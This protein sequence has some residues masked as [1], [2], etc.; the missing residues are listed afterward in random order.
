MKK[1]AIL[2]LTALTVILITACAWATTYYVNPGES[3]QAAINSSV[4]GDVVIVSPGTYYENIN[5]NGKDIV[6]TS[7]DPTD[8]IIRNATIIDAGYSGSVVS[9]NGSESSACV[10]SG[11]TIFNGRGTWNSYGY[12]GGGIYGNNTNATIQDN[13]IKNNISGYGGGLALCDGLIKDNIITG[14]TVNVSYGNGAG[15]HQCDGTIQGN[16][17]TYNIANGSKTS[18][19]GID[20][21]YGTIQNNIISN[22]SAAF[23]AGISGGRGIIINNIISGNSAI[24][25]GGLKWS[26]GRIQH[27]TIVGNTATESGGGLDSIASWYSHSGIYNNIIWGNDAPAGAQI[28][29]SYSPEY[30]CIQDWTGGGTGNINGNPLFVEPGYWDGENTW[31]EGDYHLLPWSPCINMGDPNGDYSGQVDMD[32]EPRVMWGRVDMGADEIIEPVYVDVAITPTTLNLASN[33]KWITCYIWLPE[34]YDPDDVYCCIVIDGIEVEADRVHSNESGQYITAKFNRD[35]IDYLL[36]PG[37]VELTVFC[38]T[39]DGTWFTG[40]DTITV[41]DKGNNK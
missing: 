1:H 36:E 2:V 24:S 10:L 16:I 18:G 28:N 27:N 35:D 31:V 23:G 6:L 11:F 15:L 17:I 37:N 39:S 32:G 4:N 40:T 26:H 41:L 33:G 5:L 8:E 38:Q 19:G 34:G 7:I 22:N 29:N 13:L 25:G 12:F 20:H 9:F 21:S 14:N 3:I 30:S